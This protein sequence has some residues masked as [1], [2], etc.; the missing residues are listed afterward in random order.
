MDEL[1]VATMSSKEKV[2][3]FNQIFTT[4][5][6]KFQPEAKPTQELKIEVYANALPTS[7]S[8]FVKRVVKRTLA[9]NFEE[10]KTI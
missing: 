8:M 9:E 5:L 2:K 3:Y 4:I 7:I 6:N 10:A 1:F